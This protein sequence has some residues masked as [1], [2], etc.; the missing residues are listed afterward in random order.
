MVSKGLI[1][2]VTERVLAALGSGSFR[3]ESEDKEGD[4]GHAWIGLK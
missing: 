2:L 3:S 4:G 1:F